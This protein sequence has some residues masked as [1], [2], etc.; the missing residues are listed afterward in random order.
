MNTFLVILVVALVTMALRF[1]PIY[2]FGKNGKALP[3]PLAD[4]TLLMPGAVIALL[5][6]YSLKGTVLTDPAS[7]VSSALGVLTAALLQFYRKNTL[8]SVF[9]A[10]AVYMAVSRLLAV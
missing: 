4:L 10:T 1:L 7:V 9:A 5:V 6:V 3:K 2:L 8:L